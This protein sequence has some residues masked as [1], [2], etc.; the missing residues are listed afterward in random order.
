LFAAVAAAVAIEGKM[1]HQPSR[2][3]APV[4]SM[5]QMLPLG[6]WIWVKC[7]FQKARVAKTCE[8][9]P[10]QQPSPLCCPTR[11]VQLRGLWHVCADQRQPRWHL[12]PRA[13]RAGY[14]GGWPK[15]VLRWEACKVR[16]DRKNEQ[17]KS[18]RALACSHDKMNRHEIRDRELTILQLNLAL[19]H[20][21]SKRRIRW[22][23]I[24][25]K[26]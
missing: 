19:G 15:G 6:P 1:K 7:C 21:A 14:A 4:T 3:M 16:R 26:A 11:E 12:V 18:E 22:S 17:R 5:K 24:R 2:L 9:T 20:V 25:E 13:C 8:R 23:F 10:P